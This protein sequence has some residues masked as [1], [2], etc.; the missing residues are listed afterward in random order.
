MR[1]SQGGA[2]GIVL[3][4]DPEPSE[5]SRSRVGAIGNVV[6]DVFLG[7]PQR[8]LT[9]GLSPERLR[10]LTRIARRLASFRRSALLRAW[11]CGI[12]VLPEST[13]QA[14]VSAPE[15]AR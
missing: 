6:P 9:D 7:C 13:G 15:R 2:P 10:A 14:V 5:T 12:R 3:R 11:R 4:A 1:R 8:S